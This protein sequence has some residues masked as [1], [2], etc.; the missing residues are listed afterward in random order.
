[1]FKNNR[2]TVQRRNEA[3]YSKL[4]TASTVTSLSPESRYQPRQLDGAT[5]TCW[6]GSPGNAATSLPSDDGRPSTT[7]PRSTRTPP[8]EEGGSSSET[9]LRP[10]QLDL[11]TTS[12]AAAEPVASTSK[13]ASISSTLDDDDDDILLPDS[14]DDDDDGGASCPGCGQRRRPRPPLEI[15]YTI[16]DLDLVDQQQRQQRFQNRGA[17]PGTVQ[18]N[19]V[20]RS[21][22]SPDD[23]LRDLRKHASL[24]AEIRWEL[25]SS[26]TDVDLA[27]AARSRCSCHSLTT[28]PGDSSKQKRSDLRKHHSAEGDKWSLKPES[29][30]PHHHELRKHLSHDSRMDQRDQQPQQQRTWTTLQVPELHANPKRC[31]CPKAPAPPPAISPQV[32]SSEAGSSRRP[33]PNQLSPRTLSPDEGS[34]RPSRSLSPDVPSSQELLQKRLSADSRSSR[35]ASPPQPVQPPAPA[36]PAAVTT[37]PQPPATKSKPPRSSKKDKA[38]ERKAMRSKWAGKPHFSLPAG[39]DPR[40]GKEYKDPKSKSLKERPKYSVRRSMSP[41]PDPRRVL[42]IN[43]RVVRRLIS[44]EVSLQDAKWAPY[45][46]Y[47]PLPTIGIKKRD[48]KKMISDIKW[49][50]YD[51]ESPIKSTDEELPEEEEEDPTRP[52]SPFLNITPTH[53]PPPAATPQRQDDGK[54]D[55]DEDFRWRMLNQVSAFPLYQGAWRDESPPPEQEPVW[56]PQSPPHSPLPQKQ[57][58]PPPVERKRS[59]LKSR[60]SGRKKSQVK[61]QVSIS[62]A[63]VAEEPEQRRRRPKLLRSK[64]LTLDV[65]QP[66]MDK[67]SLSEEVRYNARS[68]SMHKARVAAGLKFRAKSE[69]APRGYGDPWDQR[70]GELREYVTTV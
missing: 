52:W 1:M 48:T 21:F 65:P 66:R 31:T 23:A 15:S 45:E 26:R 7:T 40:V 4:V 38:E 62:V 58:S 47:S 63:P 54:S 67:R 32:S 46:G 24:G 22:L 37:S 3:C 68:E 29:A 56:S 11:P 6:C 43:N 33:S 70:A 39:P 59:T 36:P 50:P 64:A 10:T 17:R 18:D 61:A 14:S 69:D 27:A 49:R 34:R 28:P 41:D 30:E 12:A 51:G 20:S 53:M 9:K 8:P 19:R 16:E 44:P 5:H 55:D 60:T 2:P 42:V 57:P 35:A 25:H 13:S